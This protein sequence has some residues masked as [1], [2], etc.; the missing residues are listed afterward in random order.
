MLLH[1][2]RLEAKAS[3]EAARRKKDRHGKSRERER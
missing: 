3:A 2:F 1:I